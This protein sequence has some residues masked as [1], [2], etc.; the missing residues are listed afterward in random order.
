MPLGCT[1]DGSSLQCRAMDTLAYP[2]PWFDEW[3]RKTG[4]APPDFST[5]RSMPDLP[6][7]LEFY[8][9][10][11]VLGL[12]AWAERR[13]EIRTLLCR[14]FFGTFPQRSPTLLRATVLFEERE[15]GTIRSKVRLDFDTHPPASVTIETMR[16]E[17]PG[18]HPVFLTQTTHRSWAVM[19]VSRGYLSVVY[20]ASDEDDQSIQFGPIY[21]EC[22]WRTIPRRAWLAGRVIDYLE[23]VPEADTAQIAISGHSRNGKQSLIA[24]A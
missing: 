22:D 9:G 17:T 8:D 2:R 15:R 7:L 18:R 23:G 16:P 19:G 20:P 21:P 1:G 24:A 13:K 14:Y 11:K 12:A 10:T 3:M 6:D 4:E 5:L